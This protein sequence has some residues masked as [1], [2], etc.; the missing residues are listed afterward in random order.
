MYRFLSWLAIALAA[1]FLVVATA[2]YSLSV[3]ASLALAISIGTLLV[4][5]GVAVVC[6]EDVA[7]VI[8]GFLTAAVSAW[9]IIAS[10]VFSD[11]TVQNL[12][13]ASALAIGGLAI[14]GITSHELSHEQAARSGNQ[15]STERES[16][17]AAAA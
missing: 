5:I 15:G 6:R 11:P 10:Q 7:S 1:A 9:T 12:A 3:I 8:V 14:V 2:S 4:S 16:R 17:L 13:L